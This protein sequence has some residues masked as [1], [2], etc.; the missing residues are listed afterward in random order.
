MTC[1][2][3][4][5]ICRSRSLAN[6]SHSLSM[7]CESDCCYLWLHGRLCCEHVVRV[8]GVT[9]AGVELGFVGVS[10]NERNMADPCGALVRTAWQT[11]VTS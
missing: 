9:V 6:V 2:S 11:D 7:G 10:G 8:A 4:A 1:D 3:E 5:E